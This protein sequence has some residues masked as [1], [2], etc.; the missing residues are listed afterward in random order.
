MLVPI[1]AGAQWYCSSVLHTL[2][3]WPRY[4]CP[5]TQY[6]CP[7]H[8]AFCL[9]THPVLVRPVQQPFGTLMSERR[10]GQCASTQ[11]L[12]LM[13]TASSCSPGVSFGTWRPVAGSTAAAGSDLALTCFL[14]SREPFC[15]REHAV[16]ARNRFVAGAPLPA[17]HA[18]YVGHMLPHHMTCALRCTSRVA[19]AACRTKVCEK[20]WIAVLMMPHWYSVC[21]SLT[22]A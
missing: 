15:A 19:W 10:G 13:R 16:V 4:V 21:A 11:V 22:P 6:V 12:G 17:I 14:F 20:C 18:R 1:L 9:C 8:V 5:C 7:P 2:H 3:V